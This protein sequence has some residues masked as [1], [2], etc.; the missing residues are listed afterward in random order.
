MFDTVELNTTFYRLPAARTVEQWAA[1]APAGFLFAFKLGA[2]ATHRKKLRDPTSWLPNHLD[3][4]ARLGESLGPN[5]V[6]LPPHW[7]RNA[8][9][10]DE[11]LALVPSSWRWAVEVRDRS[12]LHD[13]T[14]EV[15]R[16]HRVALCVHDLLD[17][18]P[19]ELTTNWTYIRFH[20]PRA[21]TRPYHDAYGRGRLRGWADRLEPVLAAGNDVYCY[22]NNDFAGHAVADARCLR[23]LLFNG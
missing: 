17:D 9:R 5:L 15:L 12:W 1:A 4:A 6:Q 3:R 20:G 22:F 16:R 14:F 8:G 19:F 2:F 23:S 10:L 18:H 13:E 7:R 21:T 11:F